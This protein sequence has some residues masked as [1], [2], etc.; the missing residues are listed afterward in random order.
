MYNK[1]YS[2]TTVGIYT[3]CLR[4]MF[5]EAIFQ[6]I[7]KR[8]KHYPFGRRKYQCPSSRNVKKALT[9]EEVEKIYYFEPAIWQDQRAK[10]FWLFSYFGNGINPTDIAHL[11]FKNIAED[12]IT[13][14]RSKTENATR[15]APKPITICLTEDLI[16][17]I[18]R[19][20]K[21]R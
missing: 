14:E 2:K 6:G 15:L 20:G 5:N 12:Y 8:E 10:D 4:A 11:K 16:D 13:F 19:W 7:I 21:Q 1:E 3:R 18:G 17:I 9:I